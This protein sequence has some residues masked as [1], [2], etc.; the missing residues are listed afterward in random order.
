MAVEALKFI[1]AAGVLV[2]HQTRDVGPCE[3]SVRS[4]LID[5]TLTSFER[6]IEACVE[7]EVDF[8]LL[9]GDTFDEADR[10][11][12]ARVAI[13]EG[14]ESL[15][16]AGIDVF[17]VPGPCDSSETWSQ[18][19]KLPDNVSL[20]APEV[21]EP[22]AIMRHG[23]VLATLQACR[24]SI[25]PETLHPEEASSVGQSRIGPFRIGVIP[26]FASTGEVP[27]ESVV[28]T[29]L[30]THRVDYLAVPRPCSRLSVT[31][32]EQVAHCP[33]PATSMSIADVGPAGCSLIT[34]EAR[35]NISTELIPTSP[36]RRETISIKIDET[37]TWDQLM[38]AMRG[39]LESLTALDGVSVL[40]L[41]WELAGAGALYDS[42]RDEEAEQELFELLEADLSQVD[43]Q[44]MIH[45][46]T[47]H[48]ESG[49][50]DHDHHDDENEKS[51]L[52]GLLRRIDNE[53]SVTKRV[54]GQLKA[55]NDDSDQPWADR[56]TSLAGRAS[57]KKVTELCR[58]Y[59]YQWFDSSGQDSD[60]E[61]DDVQSL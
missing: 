3:E 45:R 35:V 43:G 52:T 23:N 56:L 5:A 2:D 55:R 59:G 32:M 25:A 42:L 46:L 34:V 47:L 41:N 37:A 28:E 36:I 16:E 12:R 44:H 6:I 11:L 4:E 17:V 38:A 50:Q 54:L 61:V 14:F 10:S 29:W 49:P 15:N 51:L 30:S 13:R 39:Y 24:G 60:S 18:F 53:H 22:T 33:G 8:L 26:P 57:H 7:N 48:E 1:H 31:R 40:M 9:T 20:F 21:D 58:S 19:K 27:N